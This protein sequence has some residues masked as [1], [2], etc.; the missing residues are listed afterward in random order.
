MESLE[1]PIVAI[2]IG[3]AS[4]IGPEI[5]LKALADGSARDLCRPL[6]IGDRNVVERARG[7]FRSALEFNAISALEGALWEGRRVELFDLNNI[8]LDSLRIGCPNAVTGKAMIE[9]A[10]LAVRLCMEGKVHGA[11]GGP[12]SKKAVHDAG[13]PFDG[14]PG[15]VARMSGSKFPFMMLVAGRLRVTNVTLHVSLRK[16]L[17]LIKKDLI[18][19]AIKATH[20]AV[21]TFGVSKPKIAVAALNPHA[22]EGGIFGDEDDTEIR[23]AV[24]AAN[25]LGMTVVGP[26]PADTV[27]CGCMQGPYDAYIGMYHDQAH[28]PIKVLAF[29]K[30][31]GVP[32]GVPVNFA[33]VGHGCASDIAWKGI[34]DPT[35]LI[36]T[37]KLVSRRAKPASAAVRRAG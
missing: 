26:L 15:F 9:Y 6:V 29:E 13:I 19:E 12:H 2:T 20:E 23:P 17:D 18:L 36:E 4:G 30:T 34:A 16:A 1:K 11:I 24:V 32:I 3:E 28:L 35:S 33:T 7:M 31:S 22:G 8:P 14:Y 27:F 5:V 25:Q 10:E 37:I 21:Q